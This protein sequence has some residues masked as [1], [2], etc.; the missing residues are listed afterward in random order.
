MAK[1]VDIKPQEK[2][3]VNANTNQ[4]GAAQTFGSVAEFRG[5]LQKSGNKTSDS[6][7][8]NFLK[9]KLA[10][11]PY[12]ISG[13]WEA[14]LAERGCSAEAKQLLI[15]VQTLPGF[16]AQYF[17]QKYLEYAG[18]ITD[19][20]ERN[21]VLKDLFET[22]PRER[23]QMFVSAVL[24][25][26]S[27]PVSQF[28]FSLV[29]ERGLSNYIQIFEHYSHQ[30]DLSASERMFTQI[31]AKDLDHNGRISDK[32]PGWKP[33]LDI[34]SDGFIDQSET[35]VFLFSQ[36]PK[37]ALSFTRAMK[38][39][40][41]TIINSTTL[42]ISLGGR[43][44]SSYVLSL[45]K[46]I[47]GNYP[48]EVKTTAKWYKA[49]FLALREIQLGNFGKALKI[50]EKFAEETGARP[51]GHYQVLAQNKA[52]LPFLEQYFKYYTT[53]NPS[54]NVMAVDFLEK[55]L[56]N[57]EYFDRREPSV[58]EVLALS[59]KYPADKAFFAKLNL[60][61][62]QPKSAA[63]APAV[64]SGGQP[65]LTRDGTV[66]LTFSSR[67]LEISVNTRGFLMDKKDHL[68]SKKV[69][70]L[71][72]QQ[73]YDVHD[74]VWR[75]R[76]K[77]VD[78]YALVQDTKD[79]SLYV[80]LHS[81]GQKKGSN[82]IK[83][84]P[85]SFSDANGLN[86]TAIAGKSEF[87]ASLNAKL[88]TAGRAQVYYA[89][90][91]DRDDAVSFY[92][93]TFSKEAPTA[94]KSADNFIAH[95]EFVCDIRTPAG[96]ARA[97]KLAAD[98][99]ALKAKGNEQEVAS[100]FKQNLAPKELL[101]LYRLGDKFIGGVLGIYSHLALRGYKQS[102]MKI[103]YPPDGD[104]RLLTITIERGKAKIAIEI[105]STT[106][107]AYLATGRHIAA[108]QDDIVTLQTHDYR[109][110]SKRLWEEVVV[111]QDAKNDGKT[112]AYFGNHCHSIADVANLTQRFGNIYVPAASY[113]STTA[114][115]AINLSVIDALLNGSDENEAARR[116]YRAVAEAPGTANDVIR[117]PKA[118]EGKGYKYFL[119]SNSNGIPDRLDG[120]Q[121]VSKV[122]FD[123]IRSEYSFNGV[124]IDKKSPYYNYFQKNYQNN[125]PISIAFGPDQ[126]PKTIY[127]LN[128]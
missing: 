74:H 56:V 125:H 91:P 85:V 104:P 116:A 127:A 27:L 23:P 36:G 26:K 67:P 8:I 107:D 35:A 17:C 5:Y 113:H 33:E 60:Y 16:E 68:A 115:S 6:R 88:R 73:T 59:D 41:E 44:A 63:A 119:D 15:D 25:S 53:A 105:F 9:A 50:Y 112:I 61:C 7:A 58:G 94:L 45:G 24:D 1:V 128:R 118:A 4:K 46:I 103:E 109:S 93:Q 65:E 2:P 78:A 49:E 89:V 114:N 28:Y 82:L 30:L 64:I 120:G 81:P 72:Y 97:R 69:R 96:Q 29:K 54:A 77:G 43:T 10:D 110:G 11:S 40:R 76:I 98:L 38:S 55:T 3:L 99:Q 34:N 75:V 14:Y 100:Y 84:I 47:E 101:R 20:Q 95:P 80:K 37:D 66:E 12:E 83:E 92:D 70:F 86:N 31:K 22:M 57:G 79:T 42:G 21:S 52:D 71:P 122:S 19:E 126:K 121:E 39:T 51:A 18:K 108:R 124:V 62:D 90:A 102:N 106:D 32:E 13:Y 117:R 48:A 111:G 123:P 87:Q